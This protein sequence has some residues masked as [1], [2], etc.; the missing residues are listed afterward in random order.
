METTGLS[1]SSD[2]IIEIGA[3]IFENGQI[4]NTFG[5]LVKSEVPISPGAS[6]VNHITND[7]L[8]NAPN[9]R[10]V[11]SALVAFLGD[12]LNGQTAICAHNAPFDMGF[13]KAALSRLGYNSTIYYVDTLSLAR[14]LI[15]GS[16]NYKQETLA[17]L[18]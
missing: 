4:V 3:I 1:A 8:R 16:P 10:E 18:I 13:L 6:A 11:F 7:M 14:K 17:S 12:A 9:E 2:R 15:K 5:T